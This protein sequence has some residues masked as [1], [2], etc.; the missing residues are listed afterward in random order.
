MADKLRRNFAFPMN[1]NNIV[2][3]KG[4]FRNQILSQHF[5]NQTHS[6]IIYL[7]IYLFI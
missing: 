1:S 7:F 4:E 3:G 6:L 5:K 2:N